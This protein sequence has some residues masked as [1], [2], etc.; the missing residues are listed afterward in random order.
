MCL[1]LNH[2]DGLPMEVAERLNYPRGRDAEDNGGGEENREDNS[3]EEDP[4]F[5]GPCLILASRCPAL[6]ERFFPD[7]EGEEEEEK[8]EEEEEPEEEKRSNL[9]LLEEIVKS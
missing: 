6:I 3:S 2:K 8:K 7:K 1:L 4:S 5:L 9:G